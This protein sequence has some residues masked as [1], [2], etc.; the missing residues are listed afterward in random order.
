M[1]S[2]HKN[3]GRFAPDFSEKKVEKGRILGIMLYKEE[4]QCIIYIKYAA[5]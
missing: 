2:E 1:S 3:P 4:V 5:F